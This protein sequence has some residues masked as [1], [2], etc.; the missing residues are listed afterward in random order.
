MASLKVFRAVSGF[1]DSYVAAPSRA[2]A[3]R[4]WGAST[5]LFAMGAAEVI[6]DPKLTAGPLAKPGVVFRVR[7]GSGKASPIEQRPRP[8]APPPSRKALDRAEQALARK[9]D[10]Q[11]SELAKIDAQVAALA[12]KRAALLARQ[13]AELQRLEDARRTAEEDYSSAVRAAR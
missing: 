1:H 9:R 4:A 10:A 5:D 7:R 6:T 12:D 8:K 13:E 3:L 2:A 11:K